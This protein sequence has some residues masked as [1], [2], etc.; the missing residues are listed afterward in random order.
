[1]Q[2]H[3]VLYRSLVPM[4]RVRRGRWGCAGWVLALVAASLVG[5]GNH[6]NKPDPAY[7]RGYNAGQ[8]GDIRK[9][10]NQ[11]K[12]PIAACDDI[13][14]ADKATKNYSFDDAAVYK[15]GCLD[16]VRAQGIQPNAGF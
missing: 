3:A 12:L 9:L 10:M 7:Q 4:L 5:C 8:G 13:L 15:Q 6:D 2:Q 1:M 11:G 14:T 16:A